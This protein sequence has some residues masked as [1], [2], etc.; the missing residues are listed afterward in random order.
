MEV[1]YYKNCHS[2][3]LFK[4]N[5]NIIRRN[6]FAFIEITKLNKNFIID[7]AHSVSKS[8]YFRLNIQL[9][10][11]FFAIFSWLSTFLSVYVICI[12]L[13]INSWW[14]RLDFTWVSWRIQFIIAKTLPFI[15]LRVRDV[16][17]CLNNLSC[18]NVHSA[19]ARYCCTWHKLF[20]FRLYRQNG[21]FFKFLISIVAA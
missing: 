3:T 15:H 13:L 2:V 9:Y 21:Y 17:F 11:W 5:C 18:C 12:S 4:K 8:R 19:S 20:Y 16:D 1:D 14:P 6:S 7:K 10:P